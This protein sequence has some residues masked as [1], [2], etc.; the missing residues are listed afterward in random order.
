MKE[1]AKYIHRFYNIYIMF[2]PLNCKH[3]FHIHIKVL[4]QEYIAMHIVQNFQGGS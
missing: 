4:D 1:L 3:Q 2:C